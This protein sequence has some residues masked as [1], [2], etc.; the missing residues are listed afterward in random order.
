MRYSPETLPD[1]LY[2]G[3]DSAETGLF[4]ST[5]RNGEW[6]ETSAEDFKTKVEQFAYG[7]YELGIRRGDKVSLHAENSTEWLICDL[8]ILSLGAA[9]VPIYPTQPG[10]QIKYI[11]ENSESK[12]HIVSNDKLFSETKPIIKE[13]TTVEAIIT[14]FGSEHQKLRPF[15]AILEQGEQFRKENPKLLA[16]IRESIEPDD[17]ATLIYTSGTTGV[18]KGVMLTH[19]NIAF[20]VKASLE[21]LP[22]ERERFNGEHVLSYLPLSHVFERMISYMY[23]SMGCKIHYIEVIDEVRDDMAYVKPFFLATVPRLLEKIQ[24]GVKVKG[25]ELSGLKKNLYYWAIYRTEDYNPENP[26]SGLDGIKHK[27]ADKLIYSKIRE[28]F[29]GNLS[30][31]VSGGAAL[32]PEV[33]KFM[34]AIGIICVQGYGLTETSP[35]ITVQRPGEMRIGSSGKALED[36]EIKIA[37]DKEIL[38]RGPHVMKGYFKLPEKT[39][40]VITGDGWFKTGDVGKIDDDGFL[41]I[42]DRKKSMF[43]LSTGK[44]VAPQNIE[45]RLINSGYI[46]QVVVIGYQRKFC[47]ALIV[48]AYDNVK[49]RLKR[50]GYSPSDPINK[51][52]KVLNLIQEE[53]DKA[54]KELSPWEKVKKFVL[55]KEA[56][57]IEGGELTPTQKVK[58]PVI[59]EKY[60]K[61]IE[62]M[63]EDE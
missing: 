45:N 46:D 4:T 12:I 57:S 9:N 38:T 7:L 31:V 17:L 62:S 52:E 25:Q 6:H 1:L 60:E 29:G 35:V 19:N 10:D 21:K 26:P 22:F 48:P 56:L 30:G 42:T 34:N 50:D 44:Y 33:F 37:D 3:I 61:E 27:L 20:N 53:V 15:E 18:P 55:L 32:S 2:K 40:E 24:T 39:E 43:K 59:N 36:V 11:L 41:Y 14:L 58:R 47:S 8:A 13:V 49:K 16:E 63:Y 54:N 5:K 51:D 28:L 23:I